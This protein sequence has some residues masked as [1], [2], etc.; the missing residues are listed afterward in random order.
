MTIKKASTS[1]PSH[2]GT[3]R[4]AIRRSTRKTAGSTVCNVLNGTRSHSKTSNH[5]D[6]SSAGTE[7]QNSS[8]SNSAGILAQ[9]QDRTQ[10]VVMATTNQLAPIAPLPNSEN[11][12]QLV[13]PSSPL[14]RPF[15]TLPE[16]QTALIS[17]S[18][19][20]QAEVLLA[21]FEPQASIEETLS[22][23][24]DHMHSNPIGS[25]CPCGRTLNSSWSKHL[26][27]HLSDS[28]FLDFHRDSFLSLLESIGRFGCLRCGSHYKN[29]SR[30]K[31]LKC[32]STPLLFAA[33]EPT[34][35]N[36][37]PAMHIEYDECQEA[38][39]ILQDCQTA[40]IQILHHIPKHLRR[41]FHDCLSNC[42]TEAAR[43]RPL[44]IA[45]LLC[46]SKAILANPVQNQ[47]QKSKVKL[48]EILHER[49]VLWDSDWKAQW[50]L[51][52][53]SNVRPRTTRSGTVHLQEV[54]NSRTKE[55]AKNGR[56]SAALKAL[57]SKGLLPTDPAVYEQ[58]LQKHPQGVCNLP[59]IVDCPSDPI[60]ANYSQIAEIVRSFP[61]GSAGG[62]SGLRANHLYEAISISPFDENNSCLQALTIFINFLLS[63]RA[64]SRLSPYI[65]GAILVA[66]G[67]K[68][69]G[70]RPIAIGEIF[71]RICSKFCARSSRN[72]QK[73]YFEPLQLGVGTSGGCE[74]I[75]HSV[76]SL[77]KSRGQ[78]QELAMVLV[79]LTNAF[80]NADRAI[81]LEQTYIHNRSSYAWYRY[82]YETP[83]N[84]YFG[85]YIIQSSIGSQQGDPGGPQLFSLALHPLL[86][87]IADECPSLALN[88]WYLDD[89]VL[90]GKKE[91]LCKALSIL[92][93]EGPT[94]GIF[95]NPRKCK[96]WWPSLDPEKWTSLVPF[97]TPVRESG[98]ELLG[99]AIGDEHFC[100]NVLH[101]RVL[102]IESGCAQLKELGHSQIAYQILRHCAGFSKIGYALRIFEPDIIRPIL[103]QFDAIIEDCLF[104]IIGAD[105]QE[106]QRIQIQLPIEK[107]GLAIPSAVDRSP[108]AYLCSVK[109]AEPLSRN[110]LGDN[111]QKNL[112][113]EQHI[114]WVNNQLSSDAKI[115][116][117]TIENIPKPQAKI[118]QDLDDKKFKNLFDNSNLRAKARLNS[119]SMPYSGNF[120]N[121]TPNSM[122]N[123]T[124][125]NEEFSS[126]V[127]YR[128][129]INVF[130]AS[131]FPGECP[132]CFQRQDASGDH[133]VICRKGTLHGRH[134]AIVSTLHH[135]AQQGAFAPQKE[136][137][138]LINN[139]EARPA[140]VYI[141][142]WTGGQPVAIDVSVTSPLADSY[143]LKASKDIGAAAS[144]RADM[145]R[146]KYSA[147]CTE[148]GMQ[149]TPFVLETFGGFDKDA[150]EIISK[151]SR[152]IA[153]RCSLAPGEI[154]MR[155][156]HKISHTI[157][158]VIASSFVSFPSFNNG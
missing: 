71:R 158:K 113:I 94:R 99:G 128:L 98:V 16:E 129:G 73:N 123:L 67:K 96:F 47:R 21:F 33:A 40:N 112:G 60:Q 56:F 53:N 137:P 68:D 62:G 57:L 120:L 130:D 55:Y 10:N 28:T 83:S 50:N 95:L 157:Q 15:S 77:I 108:V 19:E 58:L 148:H 89:G 153:S 135:L 35:A 81:F 144:I 121:A 34:I 76:N 132:R 152:A 151:L 61:C 6:K 18:T 104:A 101:D 43:G 66:L 116:E 117:N 141:P 65:A 14:P 80:N 154:K 39:N 44:A 4:T 17:I 11:I 90:I 27:I 92:E 79:D 63:G 51:V 145:K 114:S 64:P 23:P 25:Q 70:V 102:K 13:L 42:L 31:C 142:V 12:Q 105:L 126:L 26:T 111:F 29:N 100:R 54:N 32:K 119:L 48:K 125:S 149:F 49:L 3:T 139:S 69:N 74:T 107:G 45:K 118:C 46:F 124:F 97:A 2:Q 37:Q 36:S 1:I 138:Y 155:S 150:I 78:D 143:I 133:C 22:Q 106:H 110:L 5:R 7:S 82:C 93:T 85:D 20:K 72:L 109:K 131:T 146:E 24:I 38:I 122:W 140:D 147:I 75:V 134:N 84:L 88:V 91:D 30:K 127:R 8:G 115:Q 52:L 86:Q 103:Q 156:L 59:P 41:R 9:F 87:K 136:P